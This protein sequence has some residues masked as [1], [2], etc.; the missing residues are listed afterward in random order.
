[1]IGGGVDNKNDYIMYQA[2]ANYFSGYDNANSLFRIGK[3]AA[4]VD[5]TVSAITLNAGN[6]VGIGGAPNASFALNVS[7]GNMNVSGTVTANGTVLTSDSRWKKNVTPVM[8]GLSK[9]MALQ[10][11]TY[12]WK[13]AEYPNMGFTNDR[14]I[15][16]IAQDVEPIIPEVVHTDASGYKGISY[17]KLTAVIVGAIQQQQGEIIT[18]QTDSQKNTADILALNTATTQQSA[19]IVNLALKTDQNITTVAGLQTS[20]DTQLSVIS[21]RLNDQ[22]DKLTSLENRATT[23]ETFETQQTSLNATLQT[24]IDEL[25]ALTNSANQ[26]LSIAQL[27]LNTTDI[28]Y[29]KSVLGLDIATPGNVK[30]LGMLSAKVVE[31]GALEISVSDEASRTIGTTMIT[32]VKADTKVS[33]IDD[34][35]GS[36][37]KSIKVATSKISDK[38]KIFMSFQGDP[39]SSGWVEKEKDG[40]GIYNGFVIKLKN[41]IT[42]DTKVDWWIVQE[43]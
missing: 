25:K 33:G 6:Q 8:D 39:G 9:V 10:G 21:T 4:T 26:Q 12:D 38:S 16:F 3:G 36:D 19:D 1:V 18:L 7:G 17:D 41:P 29:I 31:G 32:S 30:L 14:Q 22:T 43:N 40:N 24:Q 15:G 13:T 35:T 11:V 28:S 20:V 2:A 34:V 27:Q 5:A 42:Q 23:L 37:G